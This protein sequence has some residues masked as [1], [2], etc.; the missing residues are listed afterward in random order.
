MEEV[1]F[2]ICS[3]CGFIWNSRQQFLCDPQTELIGY[4]V[5][6]RR[7]N[8][9]LFLFNH[10][11]CKSTI[12][13]KAE[14]FFDLYNGIIYQERQTGKKHCPG[15]CL[16]NSELSPCPAKCECAFVREILQII[17]SW[18]KKSHISRLPVVTTRNFI[19]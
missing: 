4:Q 3:S 12:A 16:H 11:S 18:S 15:Y 2:K 7:I 8:H 13:V 17:K 5:N 1:S 6:F 14:Y 9:G 19:L 10:D